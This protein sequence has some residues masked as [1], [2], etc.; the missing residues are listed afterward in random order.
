MKNTK[1]ARGQGPTSTSAHD[2][3]VSVE[4]TG[5]FLDG[6][7]AQLAD[8]LNTLIG[9]RGTG[10]TTILELVRHA[11]CCS[12]D[13]SV[14]SARARAHRSIVR[15]NLKGGRVRVMVRTRNGVEY[16]TERLAGEEPPQV[17]Q[18]GEPIAVS[19]DDIF[20]VDVFSQ[21]EIEEIAT[22]RASQLA[23]LDKFGGEAIPRIADEIERLLADLSV[24]TAELVRLDREIDSATER[25]SGTEGLKKRLEELEVA[26]GP[27]AKLMNEAHQGKVLRE[28][29]RTALK[30]LRED[31]R[32]VRQDVLGRLSALAR[33]IEERLPPEIGAGANKDVFSPAR[34]AADKL[35]GAL[36]RAAATLGEEADEIG[37]ILEEREPVL[38]ERHAKQEA[39]YHALVNRSEEES[40]RAADRRDVQRRHDAAQAGENDLREVR[41]QRGEKEARRRQLISKL[42]ELRDQRLA[43]RKKVEKSLTE[44][45]HPAV[46]VTVEF[47]ADT[48]EYKRVLGEVLKG[49]TFKHGTVVDRILESK[50]AP[51]ELARLV[52]AGDAG[53]L[54]RRTKLDEEKARKVID[55]L[56]GTGREYEIETL[57]L[58]DVPTV[59]LLDGAVYKASEKLSTGQRC[60]AILS[61]LLH[62]SE[63]P[64]L[65]DQPE[66]NLDNEFIF[67]RVV[68]SLRKAKGRRQLIFVTHN[69]NV[70][71][72]G[73]SERVFVLRS[74]GNNGRIEK[75]G[76]VDD[77]KEEIVSL[78]EGGR[79]AF[80]R[81]R[82]R[83]GE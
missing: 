67:E 31:A 32:A 5:G 83:Y 76:T 13:E 28:R 65:I 7:K 51:D 37:R 80:Q 60:T 52:Q 29:E 18:D 50:T 6:V 38:A 49:G 12:P 43:E 59:K 4:V 35:A 70:P 53:P 82:D 24:N 10:K 69:A 77:V 14:S 74:D 81:R 23:L 30:R 34:Q 47:A 45:L 64:L 75:S 72:L 22:N 3:I 16:V 8:G 55:M 61:I 40:A 79:K 73:D 63:R 36:E 15:D 46:Q 25:A 21:N 27:D 71:V 56:R 33:Q 2:T 19:P 41:R 9:G 1:S 68:E 57:E 39:E 26:S 17:L 66:D 58:A 48:T 54:A 42:H 62:D 11:L 78:L 44:A 20:K